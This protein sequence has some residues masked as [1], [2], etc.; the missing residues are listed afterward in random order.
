MNE[1]N[2]T[3]LFSNIHLKF[4][5]LT[6]TIQIKT[7]IQILVKALKHIKYMKRKH[8]FRKKAN[9]PSMIIK[10]IPYSHTSLSIWFASFTSMSYLF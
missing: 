3:C 5:S 8:F 10:M 2:K 6:P 1:K 7:K 4:S 9:L